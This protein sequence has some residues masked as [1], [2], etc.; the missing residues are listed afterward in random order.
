MK[1]LLGLVLM[2]VPAT[3]F[4]AGPFDGAWVAKLDSVQFPSKPDVYLLDKGMYSCSTCIPK[5]EVTADGQDQKV[6]GSPYMDSISVKV[7]DANTVE[8][9]TKKNG[10]RI[11]TETDTVSADGKTVSQKFIDHSSANGKVVTGEGTETRV[12]KGPAGSHAL[13]G[14]WRT[15]KVSGISEDA[16]TIVY[17]STADGLKAKYGTGESYDAKFDGKF[18]PMEGDMGHSMVSLKQVNPAT[19]EQSM[20]QDG[21]VIRVLVLAVAA[22]GK[23]MNVKSTDKRQ[24]TTMSYVM[25]KR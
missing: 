23:S 21:K 12:A 17:E 20:Q 24:G 14:S 7:V 25:E 16:L 22:D 11:G 6:T 2:A 5:I 9:V 18:V 8:F 4:A 1:K 3:L 15:D 13:S 19:I 10:K